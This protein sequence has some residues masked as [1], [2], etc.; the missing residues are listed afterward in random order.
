M[1]GLFSFARETEALVLFSG[2]ERFTSP[3]TQRDWTGQGMEDIGCLGMS[4]SQ[5]Y[6]YLGTS[7]VHGDAKT[8]TRQ[9]TRALQPLPLPA[10]PSDSP[11]C[12]GTC[13]H[14][15]LGWDLHILGNVGFYAYF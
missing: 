4:P 14:R 1:S 11:F 6:L 5:C 8:E 9:S 10:W 2:H 15:V 13:S 7:L 3:L 12:R